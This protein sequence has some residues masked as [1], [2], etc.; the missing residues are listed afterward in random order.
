MFL[1]WKNKASAGIASVFQ[2]DA[3]QKRKEKKEHKTE[4][5]ERYAQIGKLI[6]QNEWLKKIWSVIFLRQPSNHWS[7]GLVQIFLLLSRPACCLLIELRYIMD[8][9]CHILMI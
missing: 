4:I 3:I 1:R 6:T 8:T 5:N 2:N 7:I 9:D